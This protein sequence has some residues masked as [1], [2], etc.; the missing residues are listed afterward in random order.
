M[1]H[2]FFEIFLTERRAVQRHK[3]LSS[4]RECLKKV[5]Q[6]ATDL[7]KEDDKP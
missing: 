4:Q 3:N 2:P 6:E 5:L 7:L 1:E